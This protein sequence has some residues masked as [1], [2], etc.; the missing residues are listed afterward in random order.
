MFIPNIQPNE[1]YGKPWLNLMMDHFYAAGRKAAIALFNTE[2]NHR[3]CSDE[4]ITVNADHC[5]AFLVFS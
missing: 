2:M 3:F 1:V 4:Y 5:Y